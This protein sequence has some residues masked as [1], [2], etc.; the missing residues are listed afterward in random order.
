MG[1]DVT[2]S[3][4]AVK[5]SGAPS[6]IRDVP[7]PSLGGIDCLAT[8]EGFSIVTYMVPPERMIPHLHPRFEPFC[9]DVD[10]QQHA[11]VSVVTFRDQGFRL[12]KMRH[13]GFSFGQTNYRAYVTDKQTGEDVAWFLGTVLDS[14][15][16]V[17]PRL[18]WK[19]P[20]HRGR[21]S[22]STE[23]GRLA[24]RTTSSWAAADLV[25]ENPGA[26]VEA[27]LGF[28]DLERGLEIL[29]HPTTA[30]YSRLDRRLG[31]YKIWHDAMHAVTGKCVRARFDLLDTVGLVPFAEQSTPHSVLMQDAIDFAII[32]PPR[33]C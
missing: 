32:L 24:V 12:A 6:S 11:L 33:I 28:D 5:G 21:M 19:M 9:I 10:G 2:G 29:T 7:C 17:V 16:V 4:A 23:D 26:K 18:V 25:I 14:P 1:S 13:P 15:F 27:L 31:S 3:A 8:L 20:W 22:F 30:F